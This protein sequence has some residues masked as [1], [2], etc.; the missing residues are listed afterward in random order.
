MGI[1]KFSF[2]PRAV[3]HAVADRSVYFFIEH[4]PAFVDSMIFTLL[5]N[6]SRKSFR[7]PRM[8]QAIVTVLR[9]ND[10]G[11]YL[12]MVKS[13]IWV[14]KYNY[15]F[16]VLSDGTLT[17]SDIHTLRQHHGITVYIPPVPKKW[18]LWRWQ[19]IKYC[20]PK[21]LFPNEHV[22]LADAD[23]LFYK[24]PG[25]LLR[26]NVCVFSDDIKSWYALSN[27]ESQHYLHR[28]PIEK[29]NTG[30]LSIDTQYIEPRLFETLLTTVSHIQKTRSVDDHVIE[31]TAY[32]ILFR[33]MQK[34]TRVR[35]LSAGYLMFPK[36][37]TTDNH[38]HPSC[39][40]FTGYYET[41]R[42]FYT[43]VLLIKTAIF[44]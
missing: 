20:S 39:I 18:Q 42:R 1:S 4:A 5:H 33:A 44:H 35:R 17:S 22:I 21:T 10:I 37:H 15:R 28:T 2:H 40:H 3:I 23:I 6:F 7:Y 19:A 36:I 31:Q 13:L 16:F 8:N 25:E 12:V 32:A 26:K 38:P 30:L 27:V 34:R 14:T 41:E 24:T 29:M 43:I 11:S 9:H